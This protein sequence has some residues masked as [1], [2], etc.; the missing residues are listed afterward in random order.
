MADVTIIYKGETI[1]TM[2]ASGTKTLQTQGKYCEDDIDVEYVKPGGGGNQQA[3][4]DLISGALTGS[5]T[6]PLVTSVH[7]QVF[8]GSQ[9]E[10]LNF[11]N[12]VE[13][14]DSGFRYASKLERIYV[15]SAQGSPYNNYIFA[16]LPKLSVIALP[17]M[18]RTLPY[19][20]WDDVALTAVDLGPDFADFSVKTFNNC[21]AMTVLVL[22]RASSIVSLGNTNCF[23]GTRFASGGAGGTI[24]IPETLYNH[25][26][27]GTALDYKAAGSWSTIDGYGTITWAKI[28]GSIYENAYADG[29][30]IT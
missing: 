25:L 18:T 3:E 27:D 30:P 7:S 10:I 12:C 4:A 16:N 20:F 2:N 15:P 21:S 29:T 22:R 17:S 13:I 28:E 5:Y 6:N 1:A 23:D 8:N 9:V 19:A 11:P 24:Y 14:K 26:G